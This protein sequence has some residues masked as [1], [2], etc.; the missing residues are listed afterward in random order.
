M[1]TTIYKRSN[2]GKN[3]KKSTGKKNIRLKFKNREVTAKKKISIGRSEG[4]DIVL[5]FDS[6]VSR[7]HAVIEFIEGIYYIRDLNSMN[8]TYLNNNPLKKGETK[9][10]NIGDSIKIGNT[11]FKLT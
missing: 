8:N 4:N 11:E 6:L 5:D 2:E 3:R 7:R 10:I 9:K 1:D